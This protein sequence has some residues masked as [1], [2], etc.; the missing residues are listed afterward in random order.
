MSFI[1]PFVF[2]FGLKYILLLSPML[3]PQHQ[4]FFQKLAFSERE[5]G[6]ISKSKIPPSTSSQHPWSSPDPTQEIQFSVVALWKRPFPES[7]RPP[8][9]LA[10][11]KVGKICIFF[12]ALEPDAKGVQYLYFCI[13]NLCLGYCVIVIFVNIFFL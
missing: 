1:P 5:L 8:T 13:M 6:S 3:L 9:L 7:Q 2:D 4:E 10:F 12:Q 11:R